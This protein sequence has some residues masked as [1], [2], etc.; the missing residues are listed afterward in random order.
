MFLKTLWRDKKIILDYLVFRVRYAFLSRRPPAP[1]KGTVLIVSL[2]DVVIQAKLEGMLAKSLQMDGYEP[3]ILTN[4]SSKWTI[5]YFRAFGFR[6]FIFFNHLTDAESHSLQEEDMTDVLRAAS[7]FHSTTTIIKDGVHVGLHALSTVV[8]RI[9]QGHLSFAD[10][11]VQELLGVLLRQAI[12]CTRAAKKLFQNITP[13]AVLFFEKGY[14][15]YAPVFECAVQKNLNVIQAGHCHKGN[16]LMLKRYNADNIIEHPFSISAKTWERI[17]TM[18]WKQER[19][20]RIMES[21]HASYRDGT[22]FNRKFLLQDKKI[23]TPDEVRAELRLDPGKKIAVVFSH[24]LWDATF[25]YGNNLFEDYEQWLIETV[26]AASGNDRVQW[27][28]KVHPDYVWKMKKMGDTSE[29][30]DV[31]A[32]RSAFDSLPPHVQLLLPTTDISTY[33]L[34]DV[35]DYCITVRGTIGIEAPCFGVPTLTAGTG[36]YSGRGFTID[37]ATREEYLARLGKIEE[38][39]PMTPEQMQLARRHAYALFELRPLSFSSFETKQDAVRNL[40]H[41]LDHNLAIHLRST[42]ELQQASDLQSFSRWALDS[43]DEDYLLPIA[44]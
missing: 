35:M 5:A 25:F 3:V 18:P 43:R 7:S 13:D 28:I 31:V 8:R 4:S 38:T 29:V 19:D 42:Q 16:A 15:P 24:V 30:R 39:P 44:T 23:K 41:A 11:Q 21:L 32:L 37:S 34:F 22:W 36:R 17:R 6:T 26:R 33:S 2:H 1:S 9:R 27:I 10:P 12:V 20:D 40:G 14:I